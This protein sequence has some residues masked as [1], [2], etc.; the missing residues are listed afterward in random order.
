MGGNLP[1]GAGTALDTQIMA[2]EYLSRAGIEVE[3]VSAV[4]RT[5][6]VPASDQPD[7]INCAVCVRTS[8]S[9]QAMLDL[10]LEIETKLGRQ[11]GERWSARTLDIDLLAYG[12][13]VMPDEQSWHGVIGNPDPAYILEQ[14]V[15]PHPRLHLRGF[16]LMPLF[17]VAPD[18]RHPVL[19]E[20]VREML[21]NLP[22]KDLAGIA[23]MPD[24]F[25]RFSSLQPGR[26]AV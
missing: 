2:L 18:W 6:P 4:Y 7:F 22:A 10:C 20:T 5:S 9:P 13:L 21:E 15:V 3:A 12:A 26:G 23:R 16:V 25:G 19:G 11:R 1:S 17:D 24:A 8:L 14:A